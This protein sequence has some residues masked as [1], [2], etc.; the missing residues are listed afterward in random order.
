MAASAADAQPA[1]RE[2]VAQTVDGRNAGLVSKE[3]AHQEQT[4]TEA[5][6]CSRMVALAAAGAV[7][8][9]VLHLGTESGEPEPGTDGDRLKEVRCGACEA[10]V[11]EDIVRPGTVR[12]CRFGS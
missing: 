3:L 9:D 7:N 1:H 2:I 11:L 4:R 12:H 5:P 8:P 6:H 10:V